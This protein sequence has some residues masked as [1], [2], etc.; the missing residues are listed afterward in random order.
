MKKNITTLVKSAKEFRLIVAALRGMGYTGGGSGYETADY[1]NIFIYENGDLGGN[2][3]DHTLMNHVDVGPALA[4]ALAWRL[5]PQP[6]KLQLNSEY[7]AEIDGDNVIVGC[8]T[9]PVSKVLE[10][11]EL[12]RNK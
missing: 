8:Q 2:D 4:Q 6:I 12:I 3:I 11:A 10:L 5:A 7:T 9:C 1:N